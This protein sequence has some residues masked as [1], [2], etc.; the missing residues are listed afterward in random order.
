MKGLPDNTV[1]IYT[2]DNGYFCSAHG[3]SGKVLPYEEG[4]KAPLIVYDPRK[5]AAKRG[6]V[7]DALTGNV[8]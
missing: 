3:F 7:S 5:P 1:I 4:S 6:V 2:S 8:V